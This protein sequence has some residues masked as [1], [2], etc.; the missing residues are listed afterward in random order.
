MSKQN[1][2]RP[3]GLQP[4]QRRHTRPLNADHIRQ[5]L[6][7]LDFYRHELPNVPLKKHGWNDGG[8]CPFHADN[9]AGSFRVNL[10]TGAFKC[11]SCGAGGG[12]VIAFTMTL[13]GLKFADA[14]ARLADDWG[15]L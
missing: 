7:S 5:A 11:F 6:S 12:D 14:L 1:H 10:E 15:L 4:N 3:S 9:R 8:L 13:Y 2:S